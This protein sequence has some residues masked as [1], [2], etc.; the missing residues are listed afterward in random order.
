[1]V[2]ITF[3]LLF[4]SSSL[5]SENIASQIALCGFDL[6]HFKNCGNFG[7]LCSVLPDWPRHHSSILR[8]M[9]WFLPYWLSSCSFRPWN[10]SSFFFVSHLWS[11]SCDSN[12]VLTDHDAASYS[13]ACGAKMHIVPFPLPK[14]NFL[15]LNSERIFSAFPLLLLMASGNTTQ[16]SGKCIVLEK[17]QR[18]VKT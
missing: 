8:R 2:L 9:N 5:L 16:R 13:A 6:H 12:P 11:P 4:P 7:C 10:S 17:Y 14:H 3:L 1:M 18:W 15:D